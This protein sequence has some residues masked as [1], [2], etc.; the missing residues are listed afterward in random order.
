MKLR[1]VGKHLILCKNAPKSND[2][3]RKWVKIGRSAVYILLSVGFTTLPPLLFAAE[4]GCNKTVTPPDKSRYTIFFF[5]VFVREAVISFV[6]IQPAVGHRDVEGV[7][8]IFHHMHCTEVRTL[9]S[10]GKVLTRPNCTTPRALV[11]FECTSLALVVYCVIAAAAHVCATRSSGQQ[12]ANEST[13][14]HAK[15]RAMHLRTA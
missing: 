5:V 2:D 14:A 3:S 4:K 10:S 7:V 6:A 1:S 12:A 15:P 11:A 13:A 9:F 8:R